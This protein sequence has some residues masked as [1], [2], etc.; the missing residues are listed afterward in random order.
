MTANDY[1]EFAD[2]SLDRH[3][4]FTNEP[5]AD[6]T[7][8]TPTPFPAHLQILEARGTSQGADDRIEHSNLEATQT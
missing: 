1:A 8:L 4:E 3:T 5:Y 6:E 7:T 2:E